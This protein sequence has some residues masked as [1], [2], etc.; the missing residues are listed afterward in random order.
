MKEMLEP[1][2]QAKKIKAIEAPFQEQPGLQIPTEQ[3]EVTHMPMG[4][5]FDP[6]KFIREQEEISRRKNEKKRPGLDS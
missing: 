5:E 4:P 6:E 2:E 1:K 3:P